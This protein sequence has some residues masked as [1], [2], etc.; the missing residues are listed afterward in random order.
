[1]R[2]AGETDGPVSLEYY[3]LLR[4]P[5]INRKKP[6][7]EYFESLP[8]NVRQYMDLR[9]VL[10]NWNGKTSYFIHV[11]NCRKWELKRAYFIVDAPGVTIVE[12]D[13][14][15]H[16]VAFGLLKLDQLK[17]CFQVA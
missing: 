6:L 11:P 5:V 16:V 12:H 14:D 2:E 3:E 10:Q 8:E 1:M 17:D 9:E 15:A 13:I 4:D 7:I